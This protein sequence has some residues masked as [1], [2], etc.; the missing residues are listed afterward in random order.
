MWVAPLA[1]FVLVTVTFGNSE[2]QERSTT[3]VHPQPAVAEVAEQ[4]GLVPRAE[5]M[6]VAYKED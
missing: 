2:H 4:A 5:G 3:P 6:A 1:T